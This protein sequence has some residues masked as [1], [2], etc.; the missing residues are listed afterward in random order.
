MTPELIGLTSDTPAVLAAIELNV[1]RRSRQAVAQA[2]TVELRAVQRDVLDTQDRARHRLE[3]NL[4]DAVQQR[5]VA[6]A[7]DASLLARRGPAVEVSYALD[8]TTY[9]MLRLAYLTTAEA[10]VVGPMCAAPDGDGFQVTFEG[11]TIT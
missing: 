11:F 1:I 7:L 5:L 9:T 3:R 6:L 2:R 4:H 8:G 10:I